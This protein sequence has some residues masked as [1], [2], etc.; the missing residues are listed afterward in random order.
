MRAVVIAEH[1]DYSKLLHRDRAI[2]EP[3][4]G[5][6]R[7]RVRAAALNHLD[8][9][10]RRGVPGH[11]FPLPIIPGCDGAGVV[12][13][14]GDGV[15]EPSVGTE[16]T[17]A[18]G[19]GC[20]ACE[21]CADGQDQLCRHYGILGETRDGTCAEYICVPARNALKKPEN[22]SFEQAA[23][24]P[25]TFLTAWHMLVV[26][27]KLKPGDD[28]LVQ[29]AGSGVGV[30]AIQIA[31]LFSA[32]VIATAGSDAK[33]ARATELGADVVVNYS[34]NDFTKVVREV[35][36]KRGVD[37]AIDHLGEPT[38][39]R[40]ILCLTK[41]G[42][43]VTCGATGGF[44][45]T[46]DLRPIYFKSL[47][48]LGSTMGSLGEMHDLTRLVGSGKLK[49]VIHAVLPLDRI[50]DAHKMLGDRE[51]FGKVVVTP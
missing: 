38:I 3:K 21:T 36:K 31:K 44:T 14:L 24:F 28:V 19:Y 16:V 6:V 2:P 4:S 46:T 32:R 43:L 41:G 11:E 22:L 13:A 42:S 5:E 34:T 26:R 10:V 18:P 1:G 45:L 8:T 20:N 7:V 49:P 23:A 50:S 37:I 47:A 48:I 12:D 9:W 39:A 29:A 30:A 33:C 27:A 40:S 15:V 17:L 51:V 35:T 25:L